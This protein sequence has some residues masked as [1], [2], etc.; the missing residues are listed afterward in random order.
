MA[1]IGIYLRTSV[2]TD[3][4]SIG[5][6][7]NEALKFCKLNNFQY[8]IYEDIGRSA[9]KV[10]DPNYPFKNLPALIKLTED[11]K[12]GT[13]DKVW[14][15]E[16]SRLS[17]NQEISI[18]LLRLF[19]KYNIS[20]YERDKQYHFDDPT[21][22]LL[23][24]IVASV[25]SFER[26]AIVLR[27]TRGLRDTINTGIRNYS[28]MYG[29]RINGTH[30]NGYAKWEPIQSEI[31]NIKYSFQAYMNGNSVDSIVKE[32]NRDNNKNNEALLKKNYINVL[33]RFDY[34]G[35]SFT[36]D[37][38]EL[39]KK[40]QKFEIQNLD[41]LSEQENGK[42][43]YYLKSINYPVQIVSIEDWISI[44]DKLRNNKLVYR[45]RIRRAKSDIF[46]GLL[47]CPLCGWPYY[48]YHDNR[49]YEY[50]THKPSGACL[51]RPKSVKKD[52]INN[53]VETFYFYYYLVHDDTK[54]LLKENQKIANLK[55]SKLKDQISTIQ[56]ENKKIDKQISNFQ[57]IYADSTDKSFLKMT[58]EKEAELN[59]KLESND[60]E[61]A[62]LKFD[63]NNL[64]EEL[65]RDKMNLTY[66]DVKDL[67]L[68]FLT[69][70]DNENK[71]A[72]LIKI[73]KKCQL[74]GNYIVIS[75]G[76]I[77][78][79]FDI[80]RNNR[81]P[82][83]VFEVFKNDEHFKDNFLNSNSLL[84]RRGEYTKDIQKLMN[85]SIDEAK[86]KY[87]KKQLDDIYKKTLD[88]QQVRRMDNLII[89][90]YYLS[91]PE[92]K[93]SMQV[94]LDYLDIQFDLD[95]IIKVVSFADDI[96]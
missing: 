43:K 61:I 82:E 28:K 60:S 94:Q 47:S 73:I 88:W 12:S 33:R 22:K 86:K 50:Y 38:S 89:H 52:I 35:F 37:G 55:L 7:K 39:Y 65:N 87:T 93:K 80:R 8:L 48:F 21:T 51:Q 20:V 30:E 71:R 76:R 66:Y 68:T 5:Q 95:N 72:A 6:Q 77:L 79:Y 92:Y 10:D 70:F 54:E 90:E 40:Y 56:K 91:T 29:Y 4:T 85:T 9:Y 81:L 26:N 84:D 44:A 64:T 63:L 78:F 46:T 69:K 45:N 32:L 67:V 3:G 41:F 1:L 62:K 59:I 13:I 11:I 15:F 25:Y 18:P 34:T 96:D 36:T 49:G 74:F 31:E 24:E 53:L 75:T 83:K 19:V 27:T 17:R 16:Y 58:L 14:V 23:M 42:P 57:S 2:E